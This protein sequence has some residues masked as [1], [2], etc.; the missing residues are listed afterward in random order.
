M[1]SIH[2]DK[3]LAARTTQRTRWRRRDALTASDSLIPP[4]P[5]PRTGPRAETRV[6]GAMVAV[7]VFI[8]LSRATAGWL[9]QSSLLPEPLGA[10]AV[11]VATYLAI[12]FS[13]LAPRIRNRLEL[14]GETRVRGYFLEGMLWHA[15]LG[16]LLIFVGAS[17]YL[18]FAAAGGA[19][20]VAYRWMDCAR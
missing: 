13:L 2:T 19:G 4:T 18:S 12:L 17:Y 16:P 6:I 10:G 1:G 5:Q 8:W 9:P 3:G 11:L 15:L 7:M 14:H 20:M